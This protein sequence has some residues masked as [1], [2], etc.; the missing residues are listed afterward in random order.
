MNLFVL[1]DCPHMSAMMLSD[2]HVRKM[3]LETVQILD[4]GT[5]PIM[6]DLYPGQGPF[7]IVKI[8]WSQRDNP[9]IHTARYKVVFD[10]AA[11]HLAGLLME[12][13]YRWGKHHSYVDLL[14]KIETRRHFCEGGLSSYGGFGAFMPATYCPGPRRFLSLEEVI[15][16]YRAYYLREKLTF[17][18][19]K[20]P[21][22]WTRRELPLWIQNHM[23]HQKET[24]H[25]HG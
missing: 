5:R 25:E 16:A 6:H 1:H 15:P 3:I 11:D 22:K 18:P 2:Q 12:Y 20:I 21:A 17:G 23:Q 13:R 14:G 7:E 19:K 4:G 9:C 8:P 10:Y 24:T